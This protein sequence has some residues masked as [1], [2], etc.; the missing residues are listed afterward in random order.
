MGTTL[1]ELSEKFVPA[2]ADEIL[3]N[4]YSQTS[5]GEPVRVSLLS[6]FG[7]RGEIH[8]N[9]Y[10]D[11]KNFVGP[12]VSAWSGT[13]PCRP[14]S[15]K[16]GTLGA[17]QA[18]YPTATSLDDEVDWC[19]I[20]RVSN[21]AYAAGLTSGGTVNASAVTLKLFGRYVSNKTITLNHAAC[22]V[23]GA[24]E[25][26]RYSGTCVTYNGA[27]GTIDAPASLFDCYGHDESDQPPPGRVWNYAGEPKFVF[28]NLI[29]RGVGGALS[30]SNQAS[31]HSYVWGVRIRKA[32]LARVEHCT[33]DS[34]LYDGLVLTGPQLFLVIRECFF[35][36]IARDAIVNVNTS[37]QSGENS[38]TIWIY[39]NEFSECKR[40]A[41]LLDLTGGAVQQMPIIRDNSIESYDDNS[42]YHSNPEWNVH[43]VRAATCFINCSNLMFVAN[44]FEGNLNTELWATLHLAGSFVQ[45]EI[46]NNAINGGIMVTAHPGSGQV[47]STAMVT[48]ITNDKWSDITNTR[49]YTCASAGSPMS[50]GIENIVFRNNHNVH[51]ICIPDGCSWAQTLYNAIYDQT[52]MFFQI[53]TVNAT[54]GVG[55]ASPFVAAKRVAPKSSAQPTLF[56]KTQLG[57]MNVY[58]S[59][60]YST[61]G[62]LYYSSFDMNY[63]WGEYQVRRL[64]SQWTANTPKSKFIGTDF[65]TS[66]MVRPTDG[67]QNGFFYQCTTS[68]T[69]HASVEPTWP[70]TIG[71]TVSDGSVVW[72]CV[73]RFGYDVENNTMEKQ[74]AYKRRLLRTAAPAVGRFA[75]GDH[76]ENSAPASG[77]PPGW[78][79]TAAGSPGTFTAEPNLP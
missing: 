79:C 10:Y 35:G 17:A 45:G 62:T 41:I 50:G 49:N 55:P 48:K 4:D 72:T 52:A 30:T 16:Y 2:G 1:P 37:P 33:F 21:L 29:I 54:A 69:T 32:A 24:I 67:N 9:D 46:A 76:V 51:H 63:G 78:Y 47:R 74:E 57:Q 44:R 20:Q 59:L 38:T 31:G 66:L 71:N 15:S 75:V 64:I 40:Y 34:S 70:T 25:P 58:N 61:D 3:L 23:I 27:G 28:R 22:G 5:P 26:D 36:K 65:P 53:P 11:G 7:T 6:V 19:V 18:D 42:F 12:D 60:V 68:G 73:G 13:G 77:Q 8:V 43:G 14:L 39:D 56:G